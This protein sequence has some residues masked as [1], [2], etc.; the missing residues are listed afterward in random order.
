MSSSLAAESQGSLPNRVGTHHN[1]FEQQ[2]CSKYSQLCTSAFTFCAAAAP[3]ASITA[4][5]KQSRVFCPSVFPGEF[6][7]GSVSGHQRSQ[8]AAFAYTAAPVPSP[9]QGGGQGGNSVCQDYALVCIQ[10]L[11]VSL[12]SH[13]EINKKN[14]SQSPCHCSHL[15]PECL[16]HIHRGIR[17][18]FDWSNSRIEHTDMHQSEITCS[19]Q[20][21]SGLTDIFDWPQLPG[22]NLKLRDTPGN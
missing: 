11:Y 16:P 1:C 12:K 7:K 22:S 2:F 20:R 9:K 21:I 19:L 8:K 5:P 3:A 13:K 15:R 4:H 18:Y 10:T 6:Q 17:K 14:L